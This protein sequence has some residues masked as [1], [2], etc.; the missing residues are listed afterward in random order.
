MPTT[1]SVHEIAT[2]QDKES[3]WWNES[4][5]RGWRQVVYGH[6]SSA[7]G[8]ENPWKRAK[9]EKREKN[10]KA[11]IKSN[12]QQVQYA[13]PVNFKPF[14]EDGKQEDYS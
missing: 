13:Q 8:T 9:P 12:S 10:R 6:N 11:R 7:F 14:F 4:M 2:G 1:Y 3:K 5:K